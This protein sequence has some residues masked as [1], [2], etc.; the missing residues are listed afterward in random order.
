MIHPKA[1][2]WSVLLL[3]ALV[4]SPNVAE[5]QYINDP[6]AAP[7]FTYV[8]PN[9]AYVNS[10]IVYGGNRQPGYSDEQR[11][12]STERCDPF[13][14]CT[15]VSPCDMPYRNFCIQHHE[16][17]SREVYERMYCQSEYG[18]PRQTYVVR[19]IPEGTIVRPR[20]MPYFLV[21]ERGCWVQH[22]YRRPVCYEQQEVVCA[23]CPPPCP[24]PIFFGT[25]ISIGGRR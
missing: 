24:P 17:I 11:V 22:Y 8:N 19:T 5:A 16:I 3:A 1:L 4:F 21:Y 7:P 18:V 10:H 6:H 23:P 20:G 25:H 12:V 13:V 9:D 2:V 14:G 15:Y